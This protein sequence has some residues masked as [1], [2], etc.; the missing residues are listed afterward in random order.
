[1]S[2]RQDRK[3]ESA[4]R[5]TRIHNYK[6]LGLIHWTLFCVFEFCKTHLNGVI[7][8]RERQK[9]AVFLSFLCSLGLA[10][11]GE[12]CKPLYLANDVAELCVADQP[13]LLDAG[14]LYRR[15]HG[16]LLFGCQRNV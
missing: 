13:A 11:L 1:M 10:V 12:L 4:E 2:S 14:A 6:K 16:L 8:R 7:P 15:Q 9:N 5:A 3:I